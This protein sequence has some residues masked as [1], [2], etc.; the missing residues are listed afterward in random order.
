[1]LNI[2]LDNIGLTVFIGLVVMVV[3]RIFGGLGD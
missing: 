2:L 3:I 1:M